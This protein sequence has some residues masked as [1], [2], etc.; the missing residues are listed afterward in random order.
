M[1]CLN[2]FKKRQSEIQPNDTDM[3]DDDTGDDNISLPK[4]TT[5]QIENRLA[6]DDITNEL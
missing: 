6:R 1:Q 5:S 4:R 2:D 3:T